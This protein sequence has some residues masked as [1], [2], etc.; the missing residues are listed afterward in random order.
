M[1]KRPLFR[2]LAIG[3]IAS[4]IGIAI[5]LGIDWFP[6]QAS[7]QAAKVDLLYDITLVIAIPI[8]VIVMSVAL[9]S[10]IRYRAKPGQLEDAEPVHG[11]T[12][13]EVVWVAI[14]SVIVTVLAIYAWIGLD[15]IEAKQPNAMRVNVIG[16]QF[17]WKFEYPAEGKAPAKETNDL[18]LP[19]GRPV[20]FHMH[21]EDVIHSFW[22]PAFRVK[23]D[24]VPGIETRLRATP[25]LAGAYPVVCT[26]LCGIGHST[27]RQT[28]H[29]VS[30]GEFAAWRGAG[31]GSKPPADKL[32]AG[33]ELFSTA[34][35]AG[36]HELA[37]AKSEAATGPPLGGL[38]EVAPSRDPKEP[39]EAYVR[40]SIV[41]PKAFVVP[42]YPPE[43]MPAN[44]SQQLSPDEI[45]TLV[46]YLVRA[47]SEKPGGRPQ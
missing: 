41:D 38:A 21:S 11:N 13:L 1:L 46:K 42:G 33:R 26:E 39:I 5:G 7:E 37:D 47:S 8:F 24:I 44:Y 12:R 43:G 3:V 35:C 29:I 23:S 45:D 15:S 17:A 2:M 25:I 36:C 20:E 28:A 32:A 10:V 6:P 19:V 16:Q 30:P 27:M 34:G 14:P 9:Y 22:V 40:R 31:A 18:V 4:L